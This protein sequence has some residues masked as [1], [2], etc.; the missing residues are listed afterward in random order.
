MSR[1]SRLILSL[2]N[3]L[4][5]KRE[6]NLTYRENNYIVDYIDLSP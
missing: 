3:P 6:A 1:V 2:D 5:I 4:G